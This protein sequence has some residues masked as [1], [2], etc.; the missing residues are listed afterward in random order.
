[1]PHTPG[2]PGRRRTVTQVDLAA[3]RTLL[4][5]P[6]SGYDTVG[7]QGHGTGRLPYWFTLGDGVVVQVREHSL[8]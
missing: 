7:W 8:P 3:W 1:M 6:E 4:A 2:V 5:D